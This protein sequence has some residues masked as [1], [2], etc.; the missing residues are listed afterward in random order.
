MK[1]S[2][3]YEILDLPADATM[4]DLK[5]AYRDAMSVWHPDR[6]SVNPRLKHKAEKKAAQINLAYETLSAQFERRRAGRSSASCRPADETMRNGDP[7][8]G[9]IEKFAETGTMA[10]L[11]LGHAVYSA[12][13]KFTSPR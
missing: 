7:E 9:K 13:R 1:I 8:A 6:F 5:N 11:H 12:L 2:R 4:K 10:V 3:C